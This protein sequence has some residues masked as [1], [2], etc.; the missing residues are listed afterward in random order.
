LRLLVVAA[1]L[2]LAVIGFF[3]GRKM[4]ADRTAA[5]VMMLTPLVTIAG[6]PYG[7]EA[8]IRAFLFS[9]PGALCLVAM[10]LT[11]AGLK[12]RPILIGALTAALIPAF[13][14]ARWGN[15]LFER[16]LPGEISA[17]TALYRIAPHGSDMV[18]LYSPVTWQ[19][20]AI[21]QYKYLSADVEQYASDGIPSPAR[22]V[23]GLARRLRAN[24]H[25]G[26][27]I[28]TRSQLESARSAAGL[29][30]SWGADVERQL[31]QS[32]LFRLIYSNSTSKIYQVVD[33][34]DSSS[35]HT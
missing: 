32:N 26:Y 6:Q 9:L 27:L 5:A 3:V 29:P 1:I 21:G 18:S 31:T 13:L 7:G 25:G 34:H 30:L 10:A 16:V 8:G 11:S 12:F 17:V 23:P 2:G 24:P 35:G 15:E 14:I 4:H 33:T 19:F 22:L 28:I 20:M